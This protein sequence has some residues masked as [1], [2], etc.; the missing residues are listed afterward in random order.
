MD[1]KAKYWSKPIEIEVTYCDP[2][3][4]VEN[5]GARTYSKRAKI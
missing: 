5:N 3:P 1:M 4:E 2:T